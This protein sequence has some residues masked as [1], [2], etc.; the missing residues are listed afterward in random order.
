[1]KSIY[2]LDIEELEEYFLS[3]NDKKFHADQ[4]FSWL[5][6]KK[7]NDLSDMTNIKKETKDKLRNE[8]SFNNLEIVKI[9]KD[10]DVSKHLFKLSDKEHIEAVLM[11]HDYGNSICISSQVG[12]NMGCRFCESGRRKK[13]RN[14]TTAEMVL[15]V[16]GVEEELSEKITHVVIMGIGEPFD[17]YDNVIRFVKIINSPKG[18]QIGSRH[19]T[20]STCGI[21]PKIEE[22]MNFKYQVNLAISLHAPNN[23]LRNKIMPINKVYPIED[24]IKVLKKY[25]EKTNRRLTFEY[26]LLDGINDTKECALELAS[27]IK[28]MNA[29]VN[30]IPYND[31]DNL[32]FNRSKTIQIMRFYDILKKNK[33]NVTI[34]REFG[35]KISAACGQ[36]R[37]KEENI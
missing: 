17:N 14:L 34:R 32:G 7:T 23:R 31:T 1:M 19:I 26:I 25:I 24:L 6:Q 30:L 2:D 12:C 18:L 8:F 22:F 36:L 3:I 9:E 20:I 28:G 33:I 11:R 29:Y 16:L 27:L 35:T 21:I 13:V 37:S 15:Q 10:I 4:L 5:Y